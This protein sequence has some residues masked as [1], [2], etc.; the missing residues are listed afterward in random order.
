MIRRI[1]RDVVE[2]NRTIDGIIGQYIA[3][4]RPMHI[5]F[6]EA[7][8]RNAHIIVPVGLNTVALELVVSR[9]K[10]SIRKYRRNHGL[11]D[12]KMNGGGEGSASDLC[13]QG[14]EKQG[15]KVGSK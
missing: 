8:K 12:L 10:A 14:E 4:V 15:T 9:L 11:P 5:E 7:S 6:V 1:Q 13:Q 2:R 3:T